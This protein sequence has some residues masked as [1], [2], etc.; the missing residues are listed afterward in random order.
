MS[1]ANEWHF[2][3]AHADVFGF[4][5]VPAPRGLQPVPRVNLDDP[6]AVATTATSAMSRNHFKRWP[7]LRVHH[8][9]I[10]IL[11]EGIRLALLFLVHVFFELAGQQRA[12]I[13]LDVRLGARLERGNRDRQAVGANDVE[14]DLRPQLRLAVAWMPGDNAHGARRQHDLAFP[15]GKA[16][17]PQ[18]QRAAPAIPIA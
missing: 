13:T 6:R 5:L 10:A 18:R 7:A 15:F 16:R 4:A 17:I 11:N 2:P 9:Q 12:Q 3:Q 8:E 1:W 14:P